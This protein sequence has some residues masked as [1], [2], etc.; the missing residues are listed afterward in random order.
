MAVAWVAGGYYYF[1]RVFII[2]NGSFWKATARA[3]TTSCQGRGNF[4]LTP[5][6]CND[7]VTAGEKFYGKN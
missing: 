7:I 2:Y 5:G 6:S 3:Q 4:L 1:L